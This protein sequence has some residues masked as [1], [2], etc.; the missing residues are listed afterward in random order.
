MSGG[1]FVSKR[2]V[3]FFGDIDPANADERYAAFKLN[4]QRYARTWG[5][6]GSI[7]AA[8]RHE[9]GPVVF[10]RV[11]S[12]AADWRVETEYRLWDWSDIAGASLGKWDI[13]NLC[14]TVPAF[15][16]FVISGTCWRYLRTNWRFGLLFIYPFL[17]AVSAGL[18][19]LWLG[20]V[21]S[22]LRLPFAFSIAMGVV[23]AVLGAYLRW[24]DPAGCSWMA[25]MWL[26][27]NGAIHLKNPAL[28][29]RLGVFT[30]DLVAVL[31]S[32]QFDEILVVAHGLGSALVP[33]VIDRAFWLHPE[34]GRRGEK[35]S[36]LTLN[37]QLLTIGL[38]PEAS[39][40]IGPLSRLA[41]DRMVYW[42]DYEVL[43]D[44]LGFPGR[45]QVEVLTE[46]KGRPEVQTCEMASVHAGPERGLFSS[47]FR[48]HR[49][50]LS[51]QPVKTSF[52]YAMVCC[53]PFDLKT[54]A[55]DPSRVMDPSA[56]PR[57]TV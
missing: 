44:V 3:L 32:R 17:L 20:A 55:R 52:D 51:A 30:S 46:S 31:Q 53:G 19:G 54:R 39:W 6:S 1:S 36:L 22:N 56:T 40:L 26:F 38:H 15:I 34:F 43:G 2:C 48:R 10:W 29:Q 9:K 47:M 57:A 42:L 25:K 14:H 18:V 37:S 23:A 28:A 5:V 11:V 33:I 21:L 45:N 13:G 4:L 41:R 50:L 12:Q 16:D 49:Q 8:E 27:L 24:V 7:S 35:I